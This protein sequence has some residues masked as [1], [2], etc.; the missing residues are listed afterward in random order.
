MSD[1]VLVLSRL[2]NLDG[3]HVRGLEAV[4][5]LVMTLDR[6]TYPLA[7][8]IRLLMQARVGVEGSVMTVVARRRLVLWTK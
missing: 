8:L 6:F 2:S 7:Y 4:A 1:E 5:E 3:D